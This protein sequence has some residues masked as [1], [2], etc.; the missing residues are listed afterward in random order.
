MEATNELVES[1]NEYMF[2]IDEQVYKAF[3][4]FTCLHGRKNIGYTAT[5]KIGKKAQ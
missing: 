2:I 3:L 5:N 1:F 4:A